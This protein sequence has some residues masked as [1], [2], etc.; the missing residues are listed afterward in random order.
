[1]SRIES[2]SRKQKQHGTIRPCMLLQ[3]QKF[4]MKNKNKKEFYLFA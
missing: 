2:E 3:E 4:Y 1:M